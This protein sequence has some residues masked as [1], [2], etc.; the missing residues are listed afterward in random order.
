MKSFKFRGKN[1]KNGGYKKSKKIRSKKTSTKHTKKVKSYRSRKTYKRK[2]KG[3]SNSPERKKSKS[4]KS[5]RSVIDIRS[6]NPSPTNIIPTQMGLS[7]RL[8]TNRTLENIKEEERLRQ[9]MQLDQELRREREAEQKAAERKE[10]IMKLRKEMEEKKKNG[11]DWNKL[12]SKEK[13]AKRCEID[14]KKHK[15]EEQEMEREKEQLVEKKILENYDKK[16]YLQPEDPLLGKAAYPYGQPIVKY[17]DDYG[18][19]IT[20]GGKKKF[21]GGQNPDESAETTKEDNSVD[22]SLSGINFDDSFA[23]RSSTE[24]NASYNRF[25]RRLN[26][27]PQRGQRSQRPQNPQARYLAQQHYLEMDEDLNLSSDNE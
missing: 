8:P 12:T 23:S 14:L 22:L 26:Q 17:R 10:A 3:G 15:K 6:T 7:L 1:R 25:V 19:G 2:C 9:Q 13:Q 21:K 11:V 4:D 16:M 27:E 24:S 20:F 5:P 18:E